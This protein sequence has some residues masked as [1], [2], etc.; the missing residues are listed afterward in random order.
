V[1]LLRVHPLRTG[2]LEPSAAFIAAERPSSLEL[3]TVDDRLAVGARKDD[4]Y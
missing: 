2:A 1:R 3:V 4:S